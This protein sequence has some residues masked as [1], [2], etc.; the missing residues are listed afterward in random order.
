[1][2]GVLNM[3]TESGRKGGE[4]IR[5]RSEPQETDTEEKKMGSEILQ[6]EEIQTVFLSIESHTNL[7]PFS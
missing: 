1:M 6:G 7:S 2:N 4:A 3:H 5:L